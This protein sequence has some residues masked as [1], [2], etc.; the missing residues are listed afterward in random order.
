MNVEFYLSQYMSCCQRGGEEGLDNNNDSRLWGL[1]LDINQH[2]NNKPPASLHIIYLSIHYTGFFF[3]KNASVTSPVPVLY[4]TWRRAIPSI[5]SLAP[6]L[7][8]TVS[9]FRMCR[10]YV[11]LKSPATALYKSLSSIEAGHTRYRLTYR[12]RYSNVVKCF[13]DI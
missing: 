5:V 11:K 7:S 2:N 13:E 3:N 4:S 1:L 10:Q 6:P 9:C 8:L 12:T